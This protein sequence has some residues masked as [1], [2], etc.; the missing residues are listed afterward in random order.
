MPSTAAVPQVVDRHSTEDEIFAMLHTDP[1]AFIDM[2]A[3]QQGRRGPAVEVFPVGTRPPTSTADVTPPPP[4]PSVPVVMPPPVQVAPLMTAADALAEQLLQLPG[5][6][7]AG[8]VL[9]DPAS[10]A[11]AFEVRWLRGYEVP[12][13]PQVIDGRPVRIVIVDNLAGPQSP[14]A[15][16]Q[17]QEVDHTRAW[18]PGSPLPAGLYEEAAPMRAMVPG[19]PLPAGFYEEADHTR[20]RVPGSPL[21]GV[22]DGAWLQ[23]VSLLE[24]EAPTFSSS[25]HVGRYRQRRERLAAFGV[26]P[27]ALLGS[28]AAQRAALDA[29]LTDAHHQAAAGGVLA[30]HL[31][32]PIP[33]PGRV[34]TAAITLSGV[35]GVIQCAG[36]DGAV[37][38]LERMNDRKRYPHTTQAFLRT[39]GVF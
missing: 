5:S 11:E 32:R 15:V 9:V 16:V 2:V 39:N 1:K 20:A 25:R 35:L 26:D 21:P 24:R 22:P 23:F 13:L 36:L 29:D 14:E 3:S 4:M 27:Q 34:G 19:S 6:A 18:V 37:S 10:G 7:G 33:I 30:E 17:M 31:G 38:W 28:A 12:S 8:V